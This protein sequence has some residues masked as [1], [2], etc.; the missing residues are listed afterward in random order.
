MNQSPI[1]ARGA[2]SNPSEMRVYGVN[3]CTAVWQQRAA[4][5][6]R[7]YVTKELMTQFGPLLKWCA[8]H[9]KAYHVVDEEALAKIAQS[10]H[11]EGVLILAQAQQ[12]LGDNECLD[13]LSSRRQPTVVL[14]L[15]GVQNPHNVGAI[16]RLAA[17]FDVP[18]ILGA[19][20]ELPRLTPAAARIAEGGI[21]HVQLAILKKPKAVITELKALGFKLIGTSS[22]VKDSIYA[23]PLPERCIFVIGGEVEGASGR[24]LAFCDEVRA[25][26]GT[27]H[28]ESLN[29]AAA[30]GIFLAEFWRGHRQTGGTAKL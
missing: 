24:L 1:R 21:E 13:I 14:Y 26:P 28:V 30:T 2:S 25:I 20:G 8:K 15:D 9:K 3:A 27:G 11:H 7:V 16:V 6:I 29:V 23:S 5:I 22:H 12:P 4:S 19:E 17:H 18:M 10:V